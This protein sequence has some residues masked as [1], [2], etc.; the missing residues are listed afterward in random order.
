MHEN[1]ST[2]TPGKLQTFAM[3]DNSLAPVELEV[4]FLL[5]FKFHAE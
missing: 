2:P 3:L 4:F 1:Y 5:S